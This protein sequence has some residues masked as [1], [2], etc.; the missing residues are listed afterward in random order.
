MS[1]LGHNQTHALQQPAA[2]NERR[3][4]LRRVSPFDRT[5]ATERAF[6]DYQFKLTRD[7]NRSIND[8]ANARNRHVRNNAPA[9][10]QPTDP[11][12]GIRSRTAPCGGTL[13]LSAK[14]THCRLSSC[15]GRSHHG[16]RSRC[17]SAYGNRTP[18]R[19]ADRHAT[20]QRRCT[21]SLLIINVKSLGMPTGLS[22]SRHAPVSETLRTV[23]SIPAAR[24]N[25]I[26]PAFKTRWRWLFLSL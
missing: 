20:R 16:S 2:L 10:C 12:P 19:R 17:A 13:I 21:P 9:G 25:E 4:E 5:L 18:I 14:D 11:D 23:Q 1:A 22:I 8:Y 26:N 7:R 3:A 15:I 24:S 6:G